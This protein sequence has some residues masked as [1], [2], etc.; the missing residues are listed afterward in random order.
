MMILSNTKN[1][2]ISASPGTRDCVN[3]HGL[4]KNNGHSRLFNI[5]LAIC[6]HKVNS[7]NNRDLS[8]RTGISMIAA[9][10]RQ[11]RDDRSRIA[12]GILK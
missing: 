6:D 9:G 5:F 7:K 8:H 10:S 11:D 2:M 1:P 12:R 4:P 3:K